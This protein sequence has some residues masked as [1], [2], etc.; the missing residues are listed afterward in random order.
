LFGLDRLLETY[1]DARI[2]FTHRDPFDAMASGVSMVVHWSR[3][4]TGH[5]NAPAI[6]DWYPALWAKGLARALEVRDRLKKEQVLDL[7]HEDLSRDPLQAIEA[8][9]AHF[10]IPLS[11]AAKKRMQV[12]LRDNPRSRFGSHNSSTS[13]LGL[14]PDRENE[15]FD[16]Y[17]DRFDRIRGRS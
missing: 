3:A 16:F 6:A 10:D 4:T 12:W 1:P 9:Y 2:V 14:Q 15:R 5:A 11:R 8:V 17:I 7:F 13:A